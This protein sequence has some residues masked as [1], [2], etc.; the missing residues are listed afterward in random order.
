VAYEF[1]GLT[2]YMVFSEEVE[3]GDGDPYDTIL[4]DLVD[5]PNM[6]PSELAIMIT[7]KFKKFYQSYDR[8]KI[9]KSAVDMSKTTQL[10]NQ[11]CELAQF[12]NSNMDSERPHIQGARDTSI[13]YLYPENHDLGDF[14]KYYYDLTSDSEIKYKITE[15]QTTLSEMVISNEIYSPENDAITGSK[16]LAVFLPRR[17]EVPDTDLT[18]YSLLA[19]NQS[20]VVGDNTWGSFVNL[21]VTGDT[22]QT[23]PLTAEG[24]FVIMLKWDTDADL[25]L[26]IG[27]P[28]GNLYAPWTGTTSPNGFF[29]EDSLFSGES[30][31]NYAAAE[32]VESGTY[33]ILV[34]YYDNGPST[35]G[36]T[37]ASI[38]ILDPANGINE[39]PDQP[40]YQREMDLS[41]P[42]PGDYVG[43]WNDIMN[44][45]YT[46]W[47]WPTYL[48]RSS[49]G[50]A[51]ITLNEN[52]NLNFIVIPYK[53]KLKRLPQMD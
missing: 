30:M 3:P 8:T 49:N 46:D 4:Q 9:T 40:Q 20:R 22:G 39:F 25:D 18:R 24:N 2:D 33:D 5:N 28:N 31:E 21:L 34:N 13:N 7:E 52:I 14:L 16:G 36:P 12:M 15:I 50:E 29:S 44:D 26:Y 41:D 48:T 10:H 35:S 27:E 37:T 47:W 53:K 17:D 38:Y 19:I 42:V 43:V 23:P 45:V 11:I 6:T 32:T 51:S 1:N